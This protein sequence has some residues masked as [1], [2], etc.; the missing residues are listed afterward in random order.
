MECH[1]KI[2]KCSKLTLMKMKDR[3]QL[4]V[5][6]NLYYIYVINDILLCPPKQL[7]LQLHSI[8]TWY[9]SVHAFP[10]NQTN[11][12]GVASAIL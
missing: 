12:L 10:A 4:I 5:N 7:T 9:S 8:Y 2:S 1:I 3:T 6:I 11:D